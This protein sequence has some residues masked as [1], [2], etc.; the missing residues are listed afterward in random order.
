MAD[1]LPPP[2]STVPAGTVMP[3]GIAVGD[4]LIVFFSII[5]GAMGL[6]QMFSVNPEFANC[7]ASAYQVIKLIE[8]ESLVNPNLENGLKDVQVDGNITF[9]NARFFFPSRPTDEVI[10]GLNLHIPAGTVVGVVGH[11]G[12][13]KST[14]IALMERFHDV[15]SGAILLDGVDLKDYNLHFLRENVG[16]VAQEPTLFDMSIVENIKLGNPNATLEQVIEAAKMANAHRFIENLP[17]GYETVCG[18]GGSLLSGG[19]KQRV[20]IA[21]AVLKDPKILLLDEATSA[22]DAESEN[23]VQEALSKLM[24]GRTTIVVAHRLSTI[25]DSDLIVVMD[26]GVIVEQGK[27]M[28]L[29]LNRSHYYQLI[30]RQM[31]EEDMKVLN[32]VAE[33]MHR[34]HTNLNDYVEK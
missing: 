31:D 25:R 7:R 17:N 10:K 3:G 20:A 11:S 34:T 33:V 16:L 30:S 29:L 19:Q 18:E 1:G 14:L 4:M 9:R 5:M 32:D 24:K 21:R 8:R 22:L 12:A 26:K 27:H 6:G 2:N 13:G 15:T 28:E 23:L